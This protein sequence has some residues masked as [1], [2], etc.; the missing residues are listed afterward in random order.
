MLHPKITSAPH[1]FD[2]VMKFLHWSTLFL[3]MTVFM[4]AYSIDHVP[5]TSK[6][7]VLDL[8]RSFGVTIWIV[9]LSRLVWR[10]FTRF[11]DWPAT[12]SRPARFATTV[13]EYTLYLLLL[14]QP[15]LGMIHT[16]AHGDRVNLFFLTTL[17]A[18]ISPDHSLSKQAH[19]VH[20]IVGYLLLGLIGLHAASKLYQHFWRRDHTLT[21]MLPQ[22]ICLTSRPDQRVTG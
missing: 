20:G 6:Q 16:N 13:S 2:P 12:M 4:L 18:L 1:E 9:T 14:V 10:Q 19:E 22:G 7:L 11:P 8:H 17:P 21:A 5:F 3:V 15:V